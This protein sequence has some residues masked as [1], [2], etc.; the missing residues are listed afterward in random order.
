MA[1]KQQPALEASSAE[2]PAKAQ[3]G[4]SLGASQDTPQ[5]TPGCFF[6]NAGGAS[7]AAIHL[8]AQAMQH[9][10]RALHATVKQRPA[11]EEEPTHGSTNMGV[12]SAQRKA[13]QEVGA[14][15]QSAFSRP[16]SQRTERFHSG[17]SARASSRPPRAT[18]RSLLSSNSPTGRFHADPKR[19]SDLRHLDPHNN[20]NFF[21]PA[22][23]PDNDRNTKEAGYL[24]SQ[25]FFESLRFY[26]RFF[27]SP[28]Q[29]SADSGSGQHEEMY[30]GRPTT[31]QSAHSVEHIE[32][33]V[34]MRLGIAAA[35]HDWQ[36][37][38]CPEAWVDDSHT[39]I[40]RHIA[41]FRS[42]KMALEGLAPLSEPLLHDHDAPMLQPEITYSAEEAALLRKPRV[43]QL[44]RTARRRKEAAHNGDRFSTLPGMPGSVERRAA[45]RSAKA[46]RVR[47]HG[48]SPTPSNARSAKAEARL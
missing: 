37:W 1:E 27:G 42:R 15:W 26:P 13:T 5:S 21:A 29:D 10:T 16:A 35:D 18:A 7:R 36:P 12:W 28:R 6:C 46:A 48:G 44:L 2:D 47:V 22:G 9:G 43:P 25:S 11:M 32:S 19:R 23:A 33:E 45:L 39:A 14:P 38:Q 3:P 40:G 8:T 4:D 30:S 24:A 20:I 34:R 31:T 41:S 17:P